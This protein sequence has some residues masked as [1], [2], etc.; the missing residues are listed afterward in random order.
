MKQNETFLEKSVVEMKS[1][2][3]GKWGIVPLRL[4][5]PGIGKIDLEDTIKIGKN[6]SLWQAH[7]KNT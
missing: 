1:N 7:F 6:Q 4:V 5:P 2:N 3:F